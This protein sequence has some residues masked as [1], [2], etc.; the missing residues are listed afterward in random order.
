MRST[1]SERERL[2]QRDLVGVLESHGARRKAWAASGGEWSGSCP[3]IDGHGCG[4][5]TDRAH[6]TAAGVYGCRRCP[7]RGRAVWA[8]AQRAHMADSA[9]AAPHLSAPPAA[10]EAAPADR[11]AKVAA[12]RRVWADAHPVADTP[13]HAYLAARGVWPS[14][15]AP[16]ADM[17]RWYAP[18]DAEVLRRIGWAKAGRAGAVGALVWP[19]SA[20]PG[21][22]PVGVELEGLRGDGRRC[23]PDPR[24]GSE[25]GRWRRTLGVRAGAMWAATLRTGDRAH[26]RGVVLEGVADGLA[27]AAL[28]TAW[29]QAAQNRAAHRLTDMWRSGDGDADALMAWLEVAEAI[30]GWPDVAGAALI[31]AAPAGGL[32]IAAEVA[33]R[34]CA[35][36]LIIPDGD[37]AGAV[38]AGAATAAAHA[39]GAD[40]RTLRPW[41]SGADAPRDLAAACARWRLLGDA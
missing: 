28:S 14:G 12:A 40:T 2:G 4:G 15:W 23:G 8:A 19:L 13:A 9:P 11:T 34:D 6:V 26:R 3:Q 39:A 1:G 21:G 7:D 32:T 29:P 5:G 27:A 35:R 31:V 30:H 22:E 10:A 18:T 17:V 20:S 37:R 16:S 38:A 36:V 33:A 24:P 41:S 25:L